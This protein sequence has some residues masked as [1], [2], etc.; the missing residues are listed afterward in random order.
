MHRLATILQQQKR[1][2]EAEALHLQ[3]LDARRRVLGKDH[4]ATRL[5]MAHVGMAVQ[6]QGKTDGV[7]PYIAELIEVRRREAQEP[8]ADAR[9]LNAYARLLLTC[10]PVELRAP[11]TAL[12]VATTAAKLSGRHDAGIL[13]TLALAHKMTGNL[14]TAIE[15]Q[16]E[17]IALFVAADF[18]TSGPYERAL[19][20]FYKEA[21]I[22]A[23]WKR[24]SVSG[25]REHVPPCPQARCRSPF[26]RMPSVGF[27]SSKSGTPRPNP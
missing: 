11:A 21:G 25:W 12:E 18:M 17:A 27:F 3:T 10:E 8:D 22:G 24:G 26:E 13:D 16:K 6:A 5:S 9:T 15:T 1:P 19:A 14:G 20:D 7:G 23:R 4:P 2:A